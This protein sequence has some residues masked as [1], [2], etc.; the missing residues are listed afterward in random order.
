MTKSTKQFLQLCQAVGYIILNWALIERQIDNW[1]S[2]VFKQCH[3]N[4]LRKNKDIPRSFIQKKKFLTECLNKLPILVALRENGLE[5]LGKAFMISEQRNDL[6][7]GTIESIYPKNGVFHFHI[8]KA[9]ET[10]HTVREFDFDLN[11]FP[12]IEQSLADVVKDMLLMSHHLS[13][14]FLK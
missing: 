6:V 5:L 11:S 3:G 4:T 13:N 2:V 8:V 1:V 9:E 14:T 7:H 10:Y 12:K